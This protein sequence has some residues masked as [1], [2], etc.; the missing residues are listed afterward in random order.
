MAY[1]NPDL[2]PAIWANP[3]ETGGGRER[4]GV[5]DDRNGFVD[6]RRGWDFRDDDN[7]PRDLGL[8]PHGTAVA[9]I[10]GARADDG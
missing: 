7:D 4:N 10:I 8:L 1:D 3:G 6:D 9:G 2:A 5:N